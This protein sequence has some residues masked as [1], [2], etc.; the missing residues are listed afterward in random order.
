M[1][2]SVKT[3]QSEKVIEKHYILTNPLVETRQT[4][5]KTLE[6]ITTA[7]TLVA[8][9]A[10]NEAIKGLITNVV[11]PVV[12]SIS[13][14]ALGNLAAVLTPFIYAL[15]VT[16]LVMFMLNRLKKITERLEEKSA[17]T[18]EDIKK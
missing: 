5:S 1:E 4:V 14:Q 2:K 15:I 7:L 6:F 18:A 3:K 17:V 11:Q 8:A 13:S 9:L 10:W 12:N 16:V